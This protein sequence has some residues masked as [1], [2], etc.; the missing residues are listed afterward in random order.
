[1]V[2]RGHVL[3]LADLI[4]GVTKNQKKMFSDLSSRDR[5]LLNKKYLEE[6]AKT[7]TEIT[8]PKKNNLSTYMYVCM[9][10]VLVL[11]FLS[12]VPGKLEKRILIFVIIIIYERLLRTT[13]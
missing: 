8:P 5:R 2:P 11:F 6:L 10:T 3:N 13:I 12:T 9:Y 4:R 1:M 7:H